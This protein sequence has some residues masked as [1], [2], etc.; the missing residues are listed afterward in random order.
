MAS[1]SPSR[2]LLTPTFALTLAGLALT[3]LHLSGHDWAYAPAV[4]CLAAPGVGGIAIALYEHVEDVAEEWTWQGIVRAFAR[5]PP[6]RSFW[7]G[8]VTH[9]PQALLALLLVVRRRR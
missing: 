8:I 2:P 6:R 5:V 7:A 3:G 9:L 4:A 1:S